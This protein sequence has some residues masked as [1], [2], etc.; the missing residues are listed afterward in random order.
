MTNSDGYLE[1][2]SPVFDPFSPEINQIWLGLP[3][4]AIGVCKSLHTLS[5]DVHTDCNLNCPL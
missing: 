1:N 2:I 3:F 4:G 5:T